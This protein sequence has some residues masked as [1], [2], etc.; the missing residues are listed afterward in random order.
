VPAG[1]LN[2]SHGSALALQGTNVEYFLTG[3]TCS[4]GGK[5]RTLTL[6]GILTSHIYSVTG[7]A[8]LQMA[9]AALEERPVTMTYKFRERLPETFSDVTIHHLRTRTDRL[10]L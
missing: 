4:Y 6:L 1:S 2:S 8:S 9:G 7:T 5:I 3:T 10:P